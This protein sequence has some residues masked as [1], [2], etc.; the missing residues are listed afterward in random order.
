MRT[1]GFGIYVW[2]VLDLTTTSTLCMFPPS[3]YPL[4]TENGR[5]VHFL[6]LLTAR[7]ARFCIILRMVC[8]LVS[9]FSFLY[10]L[11]PQQK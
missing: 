9:R 5:P 10:F 1:S 8:I 11:T 3:I 2:G 6:T 7:P 4:R